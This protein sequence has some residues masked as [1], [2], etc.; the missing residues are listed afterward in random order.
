MAVTDR[1]MDGRTERQAKCTY[2]QAQA[3]TQA[4]THT[5]RQTDRQTD[6][7]T[8]DGRTGRRHPPCASQ[9]SS[10][11]WSRGAVHCGAV[12]ACVHRSRSIMK[13]RLP[14]SNSR[15]H[16]AQAQARLLSA[17]VRVR[18]RVC[19]QGEGTHHGFV[20]GVRCL[21]GKDA[22]WEARHTLFHLH[23]KMRRSGID[24]KRG[25]RIRNVNWRWPAATPGQEH[26]ET[27][28]S[29]IVGTRDEQN[30]GRC[31]CTSA[32]NLKLAAAFEHVHVQQHVLAL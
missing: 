20:N 11:S 28:A 22:R 21:V 29:F 19:T 2:T 15:Q 18:V 32:A 7:R 12:A 23:T 4:Q 6:K 25:Q 16:K 26:Q 27:L 13:M 3:Q 24:R 14:Q 8:P 1:R 17:R 31:S 9:T 30:I 10:Q 5:Y